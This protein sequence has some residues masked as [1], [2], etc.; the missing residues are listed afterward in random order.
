MCGRLVHQSIACF[1]SA[2]PLGIYIR[3][4]ASSANKQ[5]SR[6]WIIRNRTLSYCDVRK[7]SCKI[8]SADCLFAVSLYIPIFCYESKC[9]GRLWNQ[10]PRFPLL[11]LGW[12]IF[13]DSLFAGLTTRRDRR[14]FAL[15]SRL[16]A[17]NWLVRDINLAGR[18]RFV[19]EAGLRN[20]QARSP[21][22]VQSGS[23]SGWKSQTPVMNPWGD[24]KS[25]RRIWHKKIDSKT[26]AN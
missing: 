20:D 6:R 16:M 24:L 4:R 17:G 26:I 7:H 5:S 3:R 1:L 14:D 13:D 12:L 18:S 2:A 23:P 9:Q 8:T 22:S 19:R 11:S 15:E 21:A 10:F 25:K